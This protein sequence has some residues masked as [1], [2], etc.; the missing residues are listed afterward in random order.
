MN[1]FAVEGEVLRV[2]VNGSDRIRKGFPRNAVKCGWFQWP[3]VFSVDSLRKCHDDWW[4]W[5]LI[6]NDENYI[7]SIHD[8]TTWTTRPGWNGK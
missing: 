6:P 7:F 3:W 4:R 5:D 8:S 1:G 2:M